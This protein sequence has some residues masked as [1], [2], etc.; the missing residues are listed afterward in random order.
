MCTMSR[1]TDA[2]EKGRHL[3]IYRYMVK[4]DCSLQKAALQFE[5]VAMMFNTELVQLMDA[6]LLHFKDIPKAVI[7]LEVATKHERFTDLLSGEGDTVGS[8]MGREIKWR[9]TNDFKYW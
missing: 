2:I 8:L 1:V 9:S 4:E 7:K 6:A 3:D 5:D